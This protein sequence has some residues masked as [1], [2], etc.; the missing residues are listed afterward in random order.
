MAATVLIGATEDRVCASRRPGPSPWWAGG[1]LAVACMLAL[2]CSRKEAGVRPPRAVAVKAVTVKERDVPIE[3]QA[4]GRI[5]SSQSVVVRAEVSGRIV[6][7]HFTEGQNV[8][9]GDLLLEIDPRPY[10][11]TLAE[12]RARLAQDK[13]RA[14]NARA[15]ANRYRELLEKRLVAAQQHGAAA[16][17]ADALEAA[18]EGDGATVER[19]SLDLARCFIRAPGSGRTGRLLVHEGNTV[20]AAAAQPL[21]TIERRRPAYAE[22]SVPERHLA[23]LRAGGGAL[24]VWVRTEGGVERQGTLDFVDNAVDPA[25]G[26][27]LLRARL[28]NDDEA[29]WPGQ[30]AE[31]T[32]RLALRRGALVV[33][34]GAIAQGQQGDYAYVVSA[35]GTSE[36]RL[37]QAEPAGGD[38]YVVSSG[39][40][41]GERVVT[42][43]QVRLTP[44]SAVEVIGQGAGK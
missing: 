43:G 27:V 21:L 36:L 6:A 42:E 16:A 24:T 10:R 23:A 25:T 18:A 22:F 37:V 26:T 8:K 17:E 13:A 20:S 32:L 2:A 11:A 39:L 40:A 29:L 31:V 34:A 41:A 38:E 15:D 33:P 9:A 12:A 4:V 19:A 14:A 7:S 1:V 28:A 3:L 44:G 5:V 30:V 35:K